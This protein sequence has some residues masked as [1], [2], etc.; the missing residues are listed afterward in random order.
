MCHDRSSLLSCFIAERQTLAHY[1]TGR[2]GCSAT[3]DDL[4]QD[5]WLRLSRLQVGETIG[6]PSAYLRRLATNLAIDDARAN[7][8]QPFEPVAED[9][10]LTIVD[11]AP[12]TEERAADRQ[13]L[14]R[15]IGML[16]AMPHRR[17]KLLIAA[18]VEGLRHREIAERFAI[19]VRTVDTE[20]N[21]A[22]E[23]C[24][25]CLEQLRGE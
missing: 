21:R 8:R 11:E 17:R 10:L 22:R 2:T 9:L 6:N 5:A 3:A 16:G 4:L 1:L 25:A 12:G 7:A 18:R 20:L 13:E 24:A 14:E 19:S 23:Y 15:L